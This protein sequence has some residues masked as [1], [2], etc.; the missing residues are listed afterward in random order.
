MQNEIDPRALA[1][2]TGAGAATPKIIKPA[3]PTDWRPCETSPSYGPW[4]RAHGGK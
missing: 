3:P 1:A 2:V 4:L